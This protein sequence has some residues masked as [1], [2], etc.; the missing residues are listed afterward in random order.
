VGIETAH[1]T[2][3][4]KHSTTKATSPMNQAL[5]NKLKKASHWD[6][7]DIAKATS[8][9]ELTKTLWAGLRAGQWAEFRSGSGSMRE[10]HSLLLNHPSGGSPEDFVMF[11]NL[12]GKD[13]ESTGGHVVYEWSEYVER[14]LMQALEK[15]GEAFLS[16]SSGL[17]K[18]VRQQLEVA[19]MLAG[20]P[21]AVS[22]ATLEVL[23]RGYRNEGTI[24]EGH[25]LA[26]HRDAIPVDRLARALARTFEDGSSIRQR[27]LIERVWD[28]LDD[29]ERVAALV[30]YADKDRRAFGLERLAGFSGARALL[31]AE[32]ER[33]AKLENVQGGTLQNAAYFIAH[34]ALDADEEVPA[35]VDERLKYF[36]VQAESLEQDRRLFG[37]LAP[38][39]A[40]AILSASPGGAADLLPVV[41]DEALLDAAIA[42]L[43]SDHGGGFADKIGAIGP[44]ALP[45]LRRALGA[46]KPPAKLA[47]NVAR[48]LGHIHTAE[49][50]ELLVATL[51]HSSKVAREAAEVA[52]GKIGECARPALQAGVKARKKAVRT[53]CTEMLELLEASGAAE[54]SPIGAVQ[55]R[56]EAMDPA[57]VKG[58]VDAIPDLHLR[59]AYA[60]QMVETH[61]PVALLA[62]KD[63]YFQS[64]KR[65]SHQASVLLDSMLDALI[66]FKH[67]SKK[68]YQAGDAASETARLEA[69]Y[70]Y[71]DIIAQLPKMKKYMVRQLL[72]D[73]PKR[74]GAWAAPAAAMVLETQKTA[75]APVFYEIAAKAPDVTTKVLVDGLT[76]SAKAIHEPC[77]EAL[78]TQGDGVVD[79]VTPLLGA[80]K[81]QSRLAAAKVLAKI[82]SDKALPALQKAYEAESIE[83]VQMALDDA[84]RAA[85]GDPTPESSAPAEGG[86]ASAGE[87]ES[88]GDAGSAAQWVAELTGKKKP[89]L[90]KWIA[91]A[92]LPA[93]KLKTGE[94]LDEASVA[95]LIGRLKKEHERM[96]PVVWA[97]RPHLDDESAAAFG[98]AIFSAW[99]RNRAK[100]SDK[101]AL[102]QMAL[103][104][105]DAWINAM[106]P[107]LDSLSSGGK[108]AYA[109]WVLEVFERRGAGVGH[110]WIGHWA[111]HAL[112][113]GLQKKALASVRGLAKEA[114]ISEAEMRERMNPFVAAEQAEKAVPTFGFDRKGEQKVSYGPREITIRLRLD[115]T[116]RAIDE[117]GKET[118]AMPG[119]KKGDDEKAVQEA[120]RLFKKLADSAPRE[121][122]RVVRRLERAMQSGRTWDAQRFQEL[123][124]DHAIVGT[125]ASSIVFVTDAGQSLRLSEEYTPIDAAGDDVKLP[126]GAK[127]RVAHPLDLTDAELAAWGE[128]LSDSEVLQPFAQIGRTVYR[129]ADAEKIPK[130]KVKPSTYVSRARDA[131][132]N[133]GMAEDAGWVYYDWMRMPARRVNVELSHSGYIVSD[134]GWGDD[135]EISGVGFTSLTNKHLR[136]EDVDPIA[137]SEAMYA[138]MYLYERATAPKAK[139]AKAP[140]ARGTTP[141]TSGGTT[142]RA[143]LDMSDEFPSA[144][145]A[146]TSRA[147]CMHCDEKIEKKTVR[148]IVEREI[149]TPRY[150]GKGP[151]YMHPPCAEKFIDANNLDID[152]FTERLLGNTGLEL[153]QVPEAFR[154]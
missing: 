23:A 86:A 63:W 18:A 131:G 83:D 69:A 138:V 142:Q 31:A 57:T 38:A 68:L 11:A 28:Q 87:S 76:E 50:A 56:F 94:A 128:H 15:H 147:K 79:A 124:V 101:W 9:A 42:K 26:K 122:R 136:P 13:A 81:K 39:R 58:I 139:Q 78:S 146:P 37:A 109:G 44:R 46:K 107:G 70:V 60:E 96:D 59:K 77:I 113:R 141:K 41:E 30:R 25:W 51:G 93:L 123:F 140:P 67:A 16:L 22:D 52:L 20:E 125:V 64:F 45:A 108:H 100:A 92:S 17:S 21:N 91:L 48:A 4:R 35:E 49:S 153:E 33:L 47:A 112:T 6:K 119:A 24:W 73:T 14:A 5:L 74:F 12:L 89:R 129:V 54:D 3:A 8:P 118:K 120:K 148:I 137:Y 2:Y 82:G 43:D 10:E 72:R 32:L 85:G 34:L 151:G 133:R 103:F 98:K 121:I 104:A 144:D 143:L 1:L 61:G 110:D 75:L 29:A 126:E 150:K 127:L 135:I 27:E 130:D 40:G 111:D 114:S 19:Q 90:P 55:A 117:K 95:G 66:G 105:D 132:W 149:D 65:S 99:Q 80:K 134:S 115:A 97:L 106:A 36:H 102:Y 88:E 154:A 84:I 152:S 53:A 145:H 116:L 7:E 62:V 71:L